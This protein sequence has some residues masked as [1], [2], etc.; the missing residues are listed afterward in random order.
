MTAASS[1]SSNSMVSRLISLSSGGQW[2]PRADVVVRLDELFADDRGFGTDRDVGTTTVLV[3][4]FVVHRPVVG[5]GVSL[6]GTEPERRVFEPL[7]DLIACTRR[8]TAPKAREADGDLS[9]V[10][11]NS[12]DGRTE[13]DLSCNSIKRHLIVWVILGIIV[14]RKGL[15]G[16]FA[17]HYKVRALKRHDTIKVTAK[18]IRGIETIPKGYLEL[19]VKLDHRR[20]GR[21]RLGL[22]GIVLVLVHVPDEGTNEVLA[23]LEGGP[24]FRRED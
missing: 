8:K 11:N 13:S 20:A 3:A 14:P 12:S 4:T 7:V 15:S 16:G 2:V 17:V 22:G 9:S 18:Q 5:G 6:G 1:D 21:Q 23:R 24:I 10:D 19:E